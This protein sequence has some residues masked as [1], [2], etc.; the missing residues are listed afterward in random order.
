MPNGWQSDLRENCES[1]YDYVF[2]L[3]CIMPIP[4]KR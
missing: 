3:T 2:H 1:A 4:G